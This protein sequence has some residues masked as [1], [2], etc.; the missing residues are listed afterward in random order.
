MKNQI[1]NNYAVVIILTLLQWQYII[2]IYQ[3]LIYLNV[4]LIIVFRYILIHVFIFYRL[5][6]G[7]V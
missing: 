6:F 4:L 7:I 3:I 5:Q 2:I 1:K